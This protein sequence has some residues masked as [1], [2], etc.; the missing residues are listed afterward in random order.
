MSKAIEN[1][2]ALLEEDNPCDAAYHK[3]C[4]FKDTGIP[5]TVCILNAPNK[6]YAEMVAQQL[7][8]INLLEE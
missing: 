2:I 1:L 7:K 8:L 4:A 6:G 5:C 3:E